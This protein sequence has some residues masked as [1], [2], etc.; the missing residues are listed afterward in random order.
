MPGYDRRKL[1]ACTPV[2]SRLRDIVAHHEH[3]SRLYRAG[4]ELVLI[5][6]VQDCRAAALWQLGPSRGP[7]WAV[8]G[9]DVADVYVKVHAF[10]EH[11]ENHF[12]NLTGNLARRP[13]HV[14]VDNRKKPTKKET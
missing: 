1:R 12:N 7:W 9:F 4:A 10:K 2:E 11:A 8:V 5:K 3:T 6:V 13:P 14:I